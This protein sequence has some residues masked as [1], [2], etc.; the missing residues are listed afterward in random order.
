[1]KH[2]PA[3]ERRKYP[4]FSKRMQFRLKSPDGDITARSINLSR[5]GVYCWVPAPVPVM[6]KL[7]VHLEMPCVG[8]KP[9]SASVEC[10][11]VVVRSERPAKPA[12]RNPGYHIAIFFNRVNE[13]A[14]ARF[15]KFFEKPASRPISV[16]LPLEE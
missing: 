4:R 7:N 2:E 14:M 6:T 13:V 8:R 16:S 10:G 1:M 11:G 5:N 15:A 9:H 3:G 12:R